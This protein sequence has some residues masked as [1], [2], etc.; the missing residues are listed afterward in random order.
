MSRPHTKL[1]FIFT[2]SGKGAPLILYTEGARVPCS[3]NIASPAFRQA[4]HRAITS[5]G[6]TYI[7][8]IPLPGA[9]NEASTPHSPLADSPRRPSC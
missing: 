7:V 3:R 8:S 1:Y 9:T 6:L 4:R 2:R 5:I